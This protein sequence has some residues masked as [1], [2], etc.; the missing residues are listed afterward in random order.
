MIFPFNA[1][2]L[3]LPPVCEVC[4]NPLN[5][6][7]STICLN[8]YLDMPRLDL[9]RDPFNIIHRR[10]ASPGVPVERAAAFFS[11]RRQSAFAQLLRH[12]K[13]GG[14]PSINR[15]LGRMFAAQLANDGFFDGIDMLVPVPIHWTKKLRRGYNQAEAVCLGISSVTAIPI[16]ISLLHARRHTTQTRKSYAE[17]RLVTDKFYADTIV[18]LHDKHL[19][20][21]DDIITSGATMLGAVSTIL[22]ANPG[23]TVSV[24][25]LGL[26]D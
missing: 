12:A 13:Y 4:G 8:C 1:V 3:L 15:N 11:Y 23:V 9:H 18:G 24:L 6:S 19:L 7:E 14:R 22:K 16:E 17:R 20:V 2:D 10:L 5:D 25:S 26:T 21:V